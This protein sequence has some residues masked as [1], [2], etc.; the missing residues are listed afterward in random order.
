[1][2]TKPHLPRPLKLVLGLSLAALVLFVGLDHLRVLS[3]RFMVNL[4]EFGKPVPASSVPAL[5]R[6]SRWGLLPGVRRDATRL[7]G[8]AP[9]E[10]AE[11]ALRA[12]VAETSDPT[13]WGLALHGLGRTEGVEALAVARPGMI[14][15]A[16]AS[17]E[18]DA[19]ASAALAAGALGDPTNAPWCAAALRDESSDVRAEAVRC[20]ARL[21]PGEHFAALQQIVAWETSTI[22]LDELVTLAVHQDEAKARV[23]F[24]A[25]AERLQKE[26][27]WYKAVNALAKG[28][29]PWSAERLESLALDGDTRA[30]EKLAGR[31]LVPDLVRR[32]VQLRDQNPRLHYTDKDYD[33]VVACDVMLTPAFPEAEPLAVFD[34]ARAWLITQGHDAPAAPPSAPPSAPDADAPPPG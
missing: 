10:A 5:S 7:L 21:G 4:G 25:A 23:L 17:K 32:C 9:G 31:P 8:I 24:T 30:L 19:R 15:E 22:V 11:A 29:A 2:A 28:T 18:G 34:A 14:V 26:N 13:L 33:Q 1:M 20:L 16:F 6:V 12:R 3:V 27:D